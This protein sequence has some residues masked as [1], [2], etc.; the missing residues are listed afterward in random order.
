[1]NSTF[2]WTTLAEVLINEFKIEINCL[3]SVS[4]FIAK[5]GP[6]SE[7]TIRKYAKEML[8]GLEYLHSHKIMHRDLKCSN[9]LLSN[10]NEI[11]LTDF[12]SAIELDISNSCSSSEVVSSIKGSLYW[13]APEVLQQKGYG[14][15][16]DIWSLGCTIVEM[17]SAKPPWL[18][19]DNSINALLV[20]ASTNRIPHI[21]THLSSQCQGFLKE[22][23][24]RDQYKRPTAQTLLTHPFI[25]SNS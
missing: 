6:I 14:R 7:L 11:I 9:V 19:F 2:T 16:S 22:C 23:F 25:T 20:I 18:G 21:P 4:S 17:A 3:G 5:H 8:E 10:S 24:I 1:M 12:G 15:R 13:L